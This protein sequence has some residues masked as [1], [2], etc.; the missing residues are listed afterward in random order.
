M[1]GLVLMT[2]LFLGT[3]LLYRTARGKK[4]RLVHSTRD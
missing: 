3:G 2:L 4:P 1:I